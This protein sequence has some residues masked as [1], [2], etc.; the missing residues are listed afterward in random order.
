VP[1]GEMPVLSG[2]PPWPKWLLRHDHP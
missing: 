1:V 2:V